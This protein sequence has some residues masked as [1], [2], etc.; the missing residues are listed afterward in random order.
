MH[1]AWHA[2]D[3]GEEVS[4]DRWAELD[5]GDT[6]SGEISFHNGDGTS[7]KARR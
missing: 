2:A 7:F 4:G 1:L 5:E 6:I 3:E